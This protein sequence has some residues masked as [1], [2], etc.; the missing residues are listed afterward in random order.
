MRERLASREN[1]RTESVMDRRAR[2]PRRPV[3]S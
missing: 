1:R 3:R 2:I